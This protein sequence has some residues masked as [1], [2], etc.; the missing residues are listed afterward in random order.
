MQARVIDEIKTKGDEF[1]YL[2]ATGDYDLVI[3]G[4]VEYHRT[5]GVGIAP[6]AVA[7]AI[8]DQFDELI[9]V[10]SATKKFAN[11]GT[12]PASRDTKPTAAKGAT[13]AA[14]PKA[15]TL[16]NTGAGRSTVK[17]DPIDL[18][19]PDAWEKHLRSFGVVD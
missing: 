14:K 10:L 19:D 16:T 17:T 7:K 15:T 13:S 18:D 9:A 4:I 6:A 2:N 1:E 11:R 5:H 12:K 8:E 3:D